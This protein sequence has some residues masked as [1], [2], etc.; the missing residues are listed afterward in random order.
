MMIGICGKSGSGKS[1]LAKRLIEKYPNIIHVDIDKIGHKA[2]MDDRIKQEL[3][4]SFGEQV[5]NNNIIDRKKLGDIVFNSRHEMKVLTDITWEYM[6]NEIDNI[7]YSNPNK[8]ILLDWLLLPKTKYFKMCNYKILLDVDYEIR[9]QR[10]MI[11]DNISEEAF[12]LREQSSIDYNDDFDY[13]VRDT[14][15]L[16]IEGMVLKNDKSIVSG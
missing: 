2:L 9:K 8:I 11:R 14:E 6:Q 5:L 1:T 13:I 3:S 16:N 4:N 10:C 7:I 12:D 15:G